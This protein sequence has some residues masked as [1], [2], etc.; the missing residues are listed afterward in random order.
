MKV[1]NGRSKLMKKIEHT[2]LYLQLLIS[3]LLL[4]LL[5]LVSSYY[6]QLTSIEK[7]TLSSIPNYE[8]QFDMRIASESNN[9]S[10]YLEFVKEKKRLQDL[11]K[12]SDRKELYEVAKPI[13]E[14]L[15]A[16][17]DITH[18]Y[19][20]KSDGE[21]LLRVHDENRHSDIVNRYT[22]L[23]SKEKLTPYFGLEF[24]PKKNYTLRVVHPWIV[25]GELIGFIEIVKEIDKI[26]DSLSNQLGIE[27]YFGV[28]KSILDNS[29]SF[30]QKRL[31]NVYKTDSQYI[32][33][34]TTT[35]PQN[36]DWL[37]NGNDEFSWVELDES[38]YISHTETLKDVSG[39]ELGIILYLVNVTKEHSEF[40][41][42]I[43]N[44]AIIMLIG[45]FAMLLIGFLFARQSQS[46]INMTL[47]TLDLAKNRAQ[48]LLREQ[49][50]LL[51][52][53]DKGD[54]VLFKWNN[55][56]QWSIE[57]LSNNVEKVFGYTKEEFFNN[58]IIYSSCIHKDDTKR[59]SNEVQKVKEENLD[60]LKHEPY[61]IVTKSGQEKWIMDYTVTQKDST[62]AIK[63]F[64][65]YII[66]VTEQKNKEQEI[67]DKLQKF[68]DTQNSIVILTDAVQLKFTNK[69][70]LEF[71]GYKD[72]ESFS[73]YHK[74]VCDRFVQ[75]NNFFHIGKV[76]EGEANWIESILNLNGRRRVVSML[77]AD[78]TPHA[79]SVSI[80]KYEGDD[81]VITLT[82]ISD[83][84]VEKL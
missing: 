7:R 29:A 8:K 22:F 60:F 26:I 21:V 17:S 82:D 84:L 18:F 36:I 75:Q 33:Y 74:C 2:K 68:I 81:F 73:K 72:L 5:S 24:G 31:K 6:I 63:H 49:K 44:L 34:K 65:G 9:I 56:T 11:F 62:G 61:R 37:M 16:N 71:F 46:K 39:D 76:K 40:I 66:D 30:V 43:R 42:T 27:L 13:F 80:N 78:S 12:R 23:K 70:F 59:V 32:V 28:K 69:T 47:E 3:V 45:T 15:N 20:I 53:F 58:D 52:L 55:N 77:D 25:D 1:K 38:V 35:I 50:D 4:G 14:H 10:S 64:I 48:E 41:S 51:S 54:S 79:F 19:F 67:Q 83:T 57:Y